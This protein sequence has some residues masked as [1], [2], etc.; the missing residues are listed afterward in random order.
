MIGIEALIP[1]EKEAAAT[2]HREQIEAFAGFEPDICGVQVRPFTPQMFIDLEIG[3]SAFFN[4]AKLTPEDVAVFLWRISVA[5][6][7]ANPSKRSEFNMFVS[8]LP[9]EETVNACF[10]YIRRAWKPMPEWPGGRGP[11]SAGIWPSR[12]VHMFGSEYGWS[13]EYVLNL[14]F[15]RLWQ[16]ANRILESNVDRYVEKPPGVRAARAAWLR[17]QNA[18]LKN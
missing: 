14:P 7:R 4:S 8:I 2:Y 12:L 16:Y 10:E 1:G 11:Q 3:E 18:S 5:Y 17:Q 13:E 6:E 9:W 15:R